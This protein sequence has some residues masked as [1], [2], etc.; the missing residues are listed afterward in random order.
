MR[1]NHQYLNNPWQ[2]LSPWPVFQDQALR[3][4]TMYLDDPSTQSRLTS[5][6]RSRTYPHRIR[7]RLHA[8]GLSTFFA[9]A[10][11]PSRKGDILDNEQVESRVTIVH[12]SA[13]NYLTAS[14]D[15]SLAITVGVNPLA[16]LP[17][18]IAA[19]T[20]L[21]NWVFERV[22][23]GAFA[24]ML[25]T[26]IEHGSNLLR[27][28][29]YAEPGAIDEDGQFRAWRSTG[30]T[31]GREELT[32]YCLSGRKDLINGGSKHELLVV[33]ARMRQ[34][35]AEKDEY[36]PL[37]ARSD[38]SFFVVER[39]ASVGSPYHWQTLPVP[40][41][42]IASVELRE[43]IIPAAQRIGREGSGFTLAQKTLAISRGGI[44][45]MAAGL[46]HRAT[47]L[48]ATYAQER[49]IYG[50][51]ILQL[52][53]ITDHLLR[54]RALELLVTAMSV[55]AVFALNAYGSGAAHYGAVA[56]YACCVLTDELVIEGRYLFGSRG[57]LIEH[58][59]HQ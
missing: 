33:F 18:Y 47:D 53:A 1:T 49:T 24:A 17:I 11:T 43:T 55:K 32:H 3:A 45:A 42:D 4:M 44:G 41:A 52:G 30:H 48:A 6:T 34:S 31:R 57:L 36:G 37:T 21:L 59:Y 20:R 26:E 16:L 35:G 2:H 27:N 23:S 28:R 46:A 56:K 25:L 14:V 15:T 13:L 51:P 19:D 40:A 58:P 10:Q 12:L 50:E 5:F 29:T 8:L 54:M 7:D 22:R 38:F 9:D 39:D